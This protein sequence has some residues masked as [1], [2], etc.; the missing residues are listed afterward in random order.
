VKSN[1]SI[2]SCLICALVRRWADD[3]GVRGDGGPH[4]L[5]FVDD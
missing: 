4:G 1:A 3:T 2:G 5:H